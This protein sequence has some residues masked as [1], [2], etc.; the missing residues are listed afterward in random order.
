MWRLPFTT[1][2]KCIADLTNRQNYWDYKSMNSKAGYVLNAFANQ[3][4]ENALCIH[5]S[6]TFCGQEKLVIDD[7]DRSNI[8]ENLSAKFLNLFKAGF[9]EINL[10]K[11]EFT[12]NPKEEREHFE[13]IVQNAVNEIYAENFK[14]VVLARQVVQRFVSNESLVDI[15]FRISQNY[16]NA[17]VSLSYH[18]KTGY[19]IGASPELLMSIEANVFRTVAL[20]GTQRLLEGAQLSGITWSQKEIEEQA[21]VA[22]Y[23]VNCF[24]AIRLREYDDVGPRSVAAGRLVHLQT[25]FMVDMVATGYPNLAAQMMELL[26]PTSAVCGM[27][28]DSAIA[29]INENEELDRKL[30]SGYCGPVNIDG[31]TSLY[32]NLRCANI[33]HNR[34]ILYSGAGITRDSIP[35]K[36]WEETTAKMETIGEYFSI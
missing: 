23:I 28:K 14:K 6:I 25:D 1:E 26:H 15:F 34:C 21:L 36:E 27:P 32:V 5:A 9:K 29:F 33:Y 11:L 20:A 16:P 12:Y 3:N 22:R 19:W 7:F 4:P 10:P 35:E 17:F 31:N 13:K 24:K 30:F 18:P 8:D 2:V